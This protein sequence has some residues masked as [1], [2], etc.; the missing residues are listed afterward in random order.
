MRPAPG[1]RRGEI[2]SSLAGRTTRAEG[3]LRCVTTNPRTERVPRRQN[4]HQ[5]AAG[6]A[7]ALALVGPAPP[8]R[9]ADA[10]QAPPDAAVVASSPANDAPAADTRG[11]GSNA[12]STGGPDTS[13]HT[14]C[15]GNS[16]IPAARPWRGARL[17]A[18]WI[19][20]YPARVP[21]EVATPWGRPG[22]MTLILLGHLPAGTWSLLRPPFGSPSA[23]VAPFSQNL[24][25]SVKVRQGT[26]CARDRSQAAPRIP[27]RP[28]RTRTRRSLALK[29]TPEED[30][31]PEV[32]ALRER[33]KETRRSTTSTKPCCRGHPTAR[34]HGPPQARAQRSRLSC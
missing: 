30:N 7:L 12:G 5:V 11:L 15:A 17:R 13:A 6:S 23:A 27:K 16:A 3:G 20:W 25:D 2:R 18:G 22:R 33:D 26:P 4:P 8:G 31:R 9:A 28:R 24:K 29:D 21:W 34:N 10:P 1:S 14:P 32:A 19:R